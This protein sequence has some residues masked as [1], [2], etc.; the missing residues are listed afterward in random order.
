MEDEIDR[1]EIAKMLHV[2]PARVSQYEFMPVHCR[3]QGNTLFYNRAEVME[4]LTRQYPPSKPFTPANE[5]MAFMAGRF[6]APERRRE[7][8]AKKLQART[9]VIVTKRVRLKGEINIRGK[10]H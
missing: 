3:K 6:D 1:I 4:A 8:K 9:H 10:D 5:F 2:S 7:Y